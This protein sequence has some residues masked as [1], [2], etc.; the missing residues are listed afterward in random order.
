MQQL[1]NDILPTLKAQGAN[2]PEYRLLE[3]PPKI[4]IVHIGPGAFFRGHQAWYTHKALAMQGGNW[5]ISAVS[6][7]SPGVSEAL[8]PQNGLYALA[9]LDAETSYQIIGAIQEV[10]IAGSEFEQ[11][12][13][14]LSNAD[15]KFVTLTIT[16]KGYCLNTEGKLDFNNAEIQQDL[17]GQ[18]QPNTAVGMLSLALANRKA[19]GLAPLTILSCDNITDN[20]HKLRA[21]IIEFTKQ[22]DTELSTWL[23]QNLVCP[24]TMVDSIT[25]ATDDALR[26]L[27]AGELSIKDNWPIKRESF[28][29][30]VI[31]DTLPAD[32]PAWQAAGAT[33]TSDVR[34]FENAKLR[35]LNC[36]HSTL[37]YLGVLLGLETVHDAM[38]NDKIVTLIQQMIDEEIIPSFTAPKELNVKAYS[39]DILARF[40]NPAIRHLVAQIAWDGSQKLPMRILPIIE[41]NLADQRS[42]KI[43]STAVVAWFV[44]LRKRQQENVELVDPL[45][46]KLL[47]VAAACNNESQHDIDLL[48]SIDD[49]FSKALVANTTF[50]ANLQS[51]YAQLLPLLNG[52][53]L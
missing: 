14:R 32:C 7:R 10:L 46:A 39:Q 35:L 48:L 24:C 28:V 29:Q 51:A 17:T 30:W 22:S 40:R 34:G 20:G 11:V 18:K 37:A 50:K 1:S 33:L 45:A 6:M 4:G 8:T 52:G 23:E 25:P 15:T 3:N 41:Q 13:A 44:F 43:L 36:P 21:A 42:I 27:V 38:Q 53:N 16:E 49:V 12:L 47:A 19:A 26:E 31:E 5:G 9:E 2:I